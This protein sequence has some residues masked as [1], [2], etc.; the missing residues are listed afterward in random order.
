LESIKLFLPNGEAKYFFESGLDADLLIC[1]TGCLRVKALALAVLGPRSTW[2]SSVIDLHPQSA[3]IE[4]SRPS[5]DFKRNFLQ[6]KFS[7]PRTQ[8]NSAAIRTNN[9]LPRLYRHRLVVRIKS[10]RPVRR[11]RRI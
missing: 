2:P 10:Y 5:A 11:K 8:P 1:P 4:G 7:P 6:E 3:D 9:L